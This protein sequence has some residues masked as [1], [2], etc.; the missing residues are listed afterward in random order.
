M[1][2]NQNIIAE[3]LRSS[4][5]NEIEEF[6]HDCVADLEDYDLEDVFTE[7][8]DFAVLDCI[9][10]IAVEDYRV[11]DEEDGRTVSGELGITA[12]LDGFETVGS[13]NVFKDT[14]VTVFEAAFSFYAVGGKYSDIELEYLY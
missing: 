6:V 8:V 1:L 13:E 9:D 5:G 4:F 12:V 14:G 10:E 7:T 11:E 3:I 2:F